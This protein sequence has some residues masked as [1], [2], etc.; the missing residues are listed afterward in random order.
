MDLPSCEP[1][2]KVE[3]G[4]RICVPG[5]RNQFIFQGQGYPA[6]GKEQGSGNVRSAFTE[7]DD[8]AGLHPIHMAVRP[9]PGPLV[10]RHPGKGRSVLSHRLHRQLGID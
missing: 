8:R 5:D 1:Q 2:R 7:G 9:V 6:L 10:A 3:S 4:L